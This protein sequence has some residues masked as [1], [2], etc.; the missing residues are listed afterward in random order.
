MQELAWSY[1]DGVFLWGTSERLLSTMNLVL[2]YKEG[3]EG[4]CMPAVSYLDGCSCEG[5]QRVSELSAKL[6]RHC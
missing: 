3:S 4:P 6:S 5:H 1:L 2:I